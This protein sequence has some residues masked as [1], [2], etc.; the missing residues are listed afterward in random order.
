MICWCLMSWR[1]AVWKRF[2]LKSHP[3]IKFAHIVHG[4]IAVVVPPVAIIWRHRHAVLSPP[5]IWL[6]GQEVLT[7]LEVRDPSSIVKEVQALRAEVVDSQPDRPVSRV[8]EVLYVV[9]QGLLLLS[10]TGH[11]HASS[12]FYALPGCSGII[13]QAVVHQVTLVSNPLSLLATFE[14]EKKQDW[15]IFRHLPQVS[16]LATWSGL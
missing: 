7:P 2:L 8:E 9:S 5:S 10:I 6:A 1:E 16:E 13:F 15:W 3:V 12:T 11:C 4:S 14:A